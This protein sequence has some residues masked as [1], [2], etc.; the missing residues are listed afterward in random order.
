MT[1]I[2]MNKELLEEV[3]H[4]KNANISLILKNKEIKKQLTIHSVSQQRELLLAYE[5][6]YSKIHN[7]K[8]DGEDAIIIIDAFLANNCG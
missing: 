1:L 5:K 2:E 6:Y 8:Y 4:L 7:Y 3:T